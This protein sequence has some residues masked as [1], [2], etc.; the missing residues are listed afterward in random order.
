MSLFIS[1]LASDSMQ[2]EA[3]IACQWI[4]TDISR[5]TQNGTDLFTS[6]LPV[7]AF[8]L[9]SSA[10][11]H[12]STEEKGRLSFIGAFNRKRRVYSSTRL[13]NPV[14]IQQRVVD[15]RKDVPSPITRFAWV[16]QALIYHES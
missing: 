7:S 9:R 2:E 8:L 15:N 1:R 11:V 6:S 4:V 14:F 16:T 10:L 12:F 3:A 5:T 13:A